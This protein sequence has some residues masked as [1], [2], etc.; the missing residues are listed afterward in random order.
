MNERSAQLGDRSAQ[1]TTRS[2]T[3]DRG[4]RRSSISRWLLLAALALVA[5]MLLG[6]LPGAFGTA[7]AVVTPWLGFAVLLLAL[8]ALLTRPRTIWLAALPALVWATTVWGFL[9]APMQSDPSSADGGLLVATQN[10]QAGSGTGELSAQTLS[11][12]GAEVIAFTEIDGDTG[13]SI[14][15]TLT[16]SYP[17]VSRVGTV[18]VWSK[19]PILSEEPLELGLG[20]KRALRVEIDAPAGSVAIYV[21]H[22]ASVRPGAQGER[23]SMLRALGAEIAADPSPHVIAMGDF[24][25]ASTDPALDSVRG[26]LAEARFSG[27]GPSFTWPTALP[28]VRIDHVFQRGFT[29]ASAQS[30]PAGG[31]DHLAILAALQG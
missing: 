25:A 19:Y 29:R 10:V 4:S 20:W 6:N 17:N 2:G 15:Q 3:R 27:I 9:P 7:I 11:A 28:I 26:Q 18:G 30:M 16:E 23:D 21:V 8:A 24:N 1:L 13:S 5:L 31:S 14:E 22:A 12:T